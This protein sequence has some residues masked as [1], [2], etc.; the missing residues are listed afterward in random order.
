MEI[1]IFMRWFGKLFDFYILQ[2]ATLKKVQCAAL[3]ALYLS[4]SICWGGVARHARHQS[5]K[6]GDLRPE[7]FIMPPFKIA[8]PRFG[9]RWWLA[10]SSGRSSGLR[11]GYAY[12]GTAARR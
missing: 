8:G 6:R 11:N 9:A 10:R 2:K 3:I 7:F 5:N 1:S 4:S 12:S